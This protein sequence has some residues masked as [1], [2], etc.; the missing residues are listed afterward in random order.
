MQSFLFTQ[1]F[2]SQH[3]DIFISNRLKYWLCKTFLSLPAGW[4]AHCGK[5][6]P[7]ERKDFCPYSFWHVKG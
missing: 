3:Y 4:A 5:H 6:P 2:F 7:K 1:L